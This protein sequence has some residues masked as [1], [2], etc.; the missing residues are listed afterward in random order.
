MLIIGLS[1]SVMY[2]YQTTGELRR[3][4]VYVE[5]HRLVANITANDNLSTLPLKLNNNEVRYSLYTSEGDVLWYSKN[6][7]R[8]LRLKSQVLTKNWYFHLFTNIGNIIGVPINLPD[9]NVMMVSFNDHHNRELLA[10]LIALRVERMLWLVFPVSIVLSV[11]IL[12]LLLRWTLRSVNHASQAAL[13]INPDDSSQRIP[14]SELPIEIRPL[15]DAANSALTKLAN[16]YQTERRFVADAA[17]EL[18]TPLTIAMLQLDNLKQ[19]RSQN[20]KLI[21]LQMEQLQQLV[22]Q[23]L[24]LARL[25]HDGEHV[26][27]VQSTQ[28]SRSIRQV[29]AALLGHFESQKRTL[30]INIPLSAEQLKLPGTPHHF[31]EIFTNLIENALLHGQG[32]VTVSLSY[33]TEK[34]T[35]I[36]ADQGCS[37]AAESKDKLCTRFYKSKASSTGSG[38]GLAIV[39]EILRNIKGELTLQSLP[40]TQFILSFHTKNKRSNS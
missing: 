15:A 6:L 29:A 1:L 4:L 20:F 7:S 25:S 40:N 34:I 21:Q 23:L 2:M 3:T 8:P 28:L 11:I 16:A 19:G 17:H 5:A 31:N 37:L 13:Q 35:I 36:V 24:Q 9:G 32:D 33:S 27:Q 26:K 14:V 30:T 22:S 10:P 39:D 18:R 12:P 38:L